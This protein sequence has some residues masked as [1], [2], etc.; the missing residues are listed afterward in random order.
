MIS[1]GFLALPLPGDQLR[2]CLKLINS[3]SEFERWEGGKQVLLPMNFRKKHRIHTWEKLLDYRERD[4]LKTNSFPS[5]WWLPPNMVIVHFCTN[6]IS[7]DTRIFW[8]TKHGNVPHGFPM[9]NGKI[10]DGGRQL[11][12]YGLYQQC[13][14]PDQA[15]LKTLYFKLIGWWVSGT[16]GQ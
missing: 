9:R 11:L 3:I 1:H 13:N 15:R 16:S 14:G 6:F 5:T 7:L 10:Q 12:S 8:S 2:K 4:L